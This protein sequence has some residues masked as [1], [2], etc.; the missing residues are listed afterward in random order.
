M[1][2]T[3]SLD[4]IRHSDAPN[5]AVPSRPCWVDD[6]LY[7]FQSRSVSIAD[8]QVHYVDEGDG[9]VMLFL[10]GNA[11]WSFTFRHL[12]RG[13]RDHF[14]CV[15]PDLPGF[16]LSTAPAGYRHTLSNDSALVEAFIE[17]LHLRDVILLAHDT[18]GPIGLGVVARHP[19]W[20]RAVILL[21]TFCFPLN[22]DRFLAG[23][24]RLV[25][26]RFPGALLVEHLNLMV[27]QIPSHGMKLRSLSPAELAA[28]RGP[29]LDRSAR[30]VMRELFASVLEHSEYLAWLQRRL[31][32]LDLPA[33]ILPAG[34]S[35]AV[36]RLLPGLEATFAR[37]D[38]RV[39]QGAGHFSQED[40]PDQILRAIGAWPIM[41]EL[42]RR[43]GPGVETE[44]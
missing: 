34:A 5:G 18:G 9:P 26:S 31:R 32:E 38:I 29:F 21:D 10:H 7:P 37:R 27:N 14:R 36:T 20:F 8:C 3:P 39:L 25:S 13:L 33:L 44:A 17:R 35:G 22:R 12:I 43:A 15:A 16:G 4:D 2:T 30:R 28:L 24:L 6:L 11:V 1:T 23:M 42:V 19:E 41:R 40:A